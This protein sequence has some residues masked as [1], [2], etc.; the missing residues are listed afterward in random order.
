MLAT[1]KNGSLNINVDYNTF[2]AKVLSL[3]YSKLGIV[4]NPYA[5][6]EVT[7]KYAWVPKARITAANRKPLALSDYADLDDEGDYDA[8]QLEIRNS[9]AKKGAIE[10]MILQFHAVAN[11]V[12]PVNPFD[13]MLDQD[14][15]EMG[16]SECPT[17]KVYPVLM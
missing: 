10:V 1:P 14:E 6:D 12:E 11:V 16:S 7:F 8:L 4:A 2:K 13:D 5:Q 15:L 17:R 3:V 9:N